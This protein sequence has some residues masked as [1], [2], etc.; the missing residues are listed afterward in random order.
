M[1]LGLLERLRVCPEFKQLLNESGTGRMLRDPSGE[2]QRLHG[3]SAAPV[4]HTERVYDIVDADRARK[5]H[6]TR[7]YCVHDGSPR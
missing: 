1:Q 5:L 3:A 6:L 2:E 4:R 7:C